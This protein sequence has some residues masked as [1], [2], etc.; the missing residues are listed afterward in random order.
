LV[1]SAPEEGGDRIQ[2]S[3]SEFLVDK[4]FPVYW[5]PSPLCWLSSRAASAPL[6]ITEQPTSLTTL[7]E[8]TA[9]KVLDKLFFFYVVLALNSSPSCVLGRHSTT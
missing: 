6:M 7:E 2:L 9:V 8:D 4:A 3:S 5:L 1:A